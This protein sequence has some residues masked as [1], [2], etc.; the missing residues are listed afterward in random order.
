M[1][2]KDLNYEQKHQLKQSVLT[3]RDNNVSF[4]ELVN[5]DELVTDDELEER[6]G[7]TEFVKEDFFE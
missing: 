6:F 5:A 2:L 7:G 4:G 3:E 1:N